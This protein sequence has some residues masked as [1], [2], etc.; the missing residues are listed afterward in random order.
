MSTVFLWSGVGLAVA[1]LTAQYYF[2]PSITEASNP[3]VTW[4]LTPGGLVGRW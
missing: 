4:Q 3:G 1:G 2:A